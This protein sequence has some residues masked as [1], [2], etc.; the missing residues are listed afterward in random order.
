MGKQISSAQFSLV[1]SPERGIKPSARKLANGSF[2]TTKTLSSRTCRW[3][4]GNPAESS[5][6]YCGQLPSVGRPYCS[7]HEKLAVQPNTRTR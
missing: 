4:Y 2:V 5:F 3:P 6:H 1:C 7:E